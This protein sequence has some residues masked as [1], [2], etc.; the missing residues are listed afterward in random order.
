MQH[1]IRLSTYSSNDRIPAI[2][3]AR[4]AAARIIPPVV[5]LKLWPRAKSPR[6]TYL[7]LVACGEVGVKH[8]TYFDLSCV[9]GL[10]AA[11]V[12]CSVKKLEAAGL[13]VRTEAEGAGRGIHFDY[14]VLPL[15]GGCE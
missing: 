15:E 14:T 8:P 6:E 13:I 2:A 4:E 7:A 10:S 3:K 9:S 1:N 12:A 5:L 11:S